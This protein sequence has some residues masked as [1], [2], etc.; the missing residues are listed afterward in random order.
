MAKPRTPES[1][2]PLKPHWFH[3]L[4]SLSNDDQHGY[5]IMQEVLERTD[6]KIRLWP[7]TLYGTL[8]RLMDEDL[9]ETSEERPSPELDDSRR[10]YYRLTKQGRRVLAAESRRLEELVRVIRAKGGLRREASS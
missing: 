9:I 8:K 10:R 5:G 1:Y 2:L 7:A 6:G 3:V 4:L